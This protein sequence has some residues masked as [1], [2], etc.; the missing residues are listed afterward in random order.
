MKSLTYA[1]FPPPFAAVMREI[2]VM[3][4][5]EHPNVV[6]LHEVIN[7]PDS[8]NIML[9]R[10]S[11]VYIWGMCYSNGKYEL[12]GTPQAQILISFELS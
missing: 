9:V 1:T 2:A 8:T 5:M 7:L 6:K 10:L 4:K 11:T 12:S 3:E